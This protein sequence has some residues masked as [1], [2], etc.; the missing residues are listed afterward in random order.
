MKDGLE[1]SSVKDKVF[2]FAEVGGFGAGTESEAI[3]NVLNSSGLSQLSVGFMSDTVKSGVYDGGVEVGI[4]VEGDKLDAI[5]ATASGFATFF[6]GEA[7][8]GEKSFFD[9]D[10]T[11]KPVGRGVGS[12]EVGLELGGG[13]VELLVHVLVQ[14]RL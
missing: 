13:M 7:E 14:E 4:R 9:G 2:G 5:F 1:G 11:T 8:K 3:D 10:R 12:I 6:W